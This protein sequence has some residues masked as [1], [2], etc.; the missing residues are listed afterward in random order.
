M[1]RT[2]FKIKYKINIL[3]FKPDVNISNVVMCENMNP[4]AEV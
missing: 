1:P 4:L 2:V 3:L